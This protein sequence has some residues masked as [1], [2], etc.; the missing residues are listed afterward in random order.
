M[1]K[2]DALT[3]EKSEKLLSLAWL[4]LKVHTRIESSTGQAAKSQGPNREAT[5]CRFAKHLSPDLATRR[6]RRGLCLPP[7]T[8][9]P[10]YV[11]ES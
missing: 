6:I 7:S 2:S 8:E 5:H 1:S 4:H 10:V 3:N 9:I 11:D